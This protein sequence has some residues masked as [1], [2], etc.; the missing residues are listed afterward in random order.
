MVYVFPDPVTPKRVDLPGL[1][2][3]SCLIASGW[4]PDGGN[5]VWS[6]KRDIFHLFFRAFF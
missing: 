6:L 5:G 3:N 1:F 2:S 4:L